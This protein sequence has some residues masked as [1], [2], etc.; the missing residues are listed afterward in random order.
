MTAK[1]YDFKKEKDRRDRLKHI[2]AIIN[3]PT[4]PDRIHPAGDALKKL[5]EIALKA[6]KKMVSEPVII[7]ETE[8]MSPEQLTKPPNSGWKPKE[9]FIN[10][11]PYNDDTDKLKIE[12]K[13]QDDEED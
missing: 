13:I 5:N 7:S 1:I 12:I 10:W 9:P 11:R 8:W 6:M 3:D 2:A 4:N